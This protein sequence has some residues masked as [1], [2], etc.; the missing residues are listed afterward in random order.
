M[1]TVLA[2]LRPR[3]GCWR[4]AIDQ[5]PLYLHILTELYDATGEFLDEAD[6]VF[7]MRFFNE[8]QRF[9]FVFTELE[10]LPESIRVVPFGMYARVM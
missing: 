5:E 7:D 1:Y 2:S 10:T 3:N 9:K 8:I 6:W 4:P